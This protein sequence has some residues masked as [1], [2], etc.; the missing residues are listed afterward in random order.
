[1]LMSLVC[2]LLNVPL[3]NISFFVIKN[4]Y[5]RQRFSFYG[6]ILV[7]RIIRG[8]GQCSKKWCS[9]IL[10]CSSDEVQCTSIP[11]RCGH[12]SDI[13]GMVITYLIELIIISG[14]AWRVLFF[15][16]LGI[17]TP[18]LSFKS[19]KFRF[20]LTIHSPF[21]NEYRFLRSYPMTL[22]F[23]KRTVATFF[24]ESNAKTTFNMQNMQGYHFSNLEYLQ[25]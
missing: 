14:K 1:M 9:T 18:P 17:E 20:V 7:T 16:L 24:N 19:D 13:S 3:K 10:S 25:S 22:A 11:L 23:V 8:T 12:A 5:I 6:G 21:G 15:V 2:W 4:H